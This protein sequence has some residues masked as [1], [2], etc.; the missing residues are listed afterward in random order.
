MPEREF[1]DAEGNPWYVSEV[2]SGSLGRYSLL[3]QLRRVAPADDVS[4]ALGRAL[5]AGA[6]HAPQGRRSGRGN[7]AGGEDWQCNSNQ[8]DGMA[9]NE[10]TSPAIAKVASKALKT[11]EA[12]KAEIKKLAASVLT[13]AADRKPAPKKGKK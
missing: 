10:K 11:G 6:L 3:R 7:G 12:T 13:Q 4:A 9:K 8:G 2:F 5:Q 1:T